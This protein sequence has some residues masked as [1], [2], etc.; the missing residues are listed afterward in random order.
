MI[1]NANKVLLALL[2]TS[3][4]LWPTGCARNSGDNPGLAKPDAVIPE[5][6]SPDAASPPDSN[7]AGVA[8]PPDSSAGDGGFVDAVVDAFAADRSSDTLEPIRV[9]GGAA[10]D[11]GYLGCLVLGQDFSGLDGNIVTVRIGRPGRG[12]RLGSG[13]VRIEQGAFSI[14]L[15]A[16]IENSLYKQKIVHVDADGDGIC[17]ADDFIF[18][19]FSANES[20]PPKDFVF[21]VSPTSPFNRARPEEFTRLCEDIRN[22]P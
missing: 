13:Q 7:P 21:M 22:W 15:P 14:R 10:G 3:T 17:G 6:S 11:A 4:C 5:T 18:T 2:S 16:A 19:D 1:R 8:P 12:E 20:N 9:V